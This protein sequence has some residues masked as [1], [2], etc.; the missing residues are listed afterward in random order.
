MVNAITFA[1]HCNFVKR[2]FL[3]TD[4]HLLIDKVDDKADRMEDNQ[5]KALLAAW[6][7]G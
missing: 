4:V 2:L 7:K 3:T 6:W 1:L 5:N